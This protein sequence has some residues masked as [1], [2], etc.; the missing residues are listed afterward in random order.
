M[1]CLP[2]VAVICP[3]PQPPEVGW[4]ELQQLDELA[5]DGV[6][7]ERWS[8]EQMA[9]SRTMATTTFWEIPSN[10]SRDFSGTF[11]GHL[12]KGSPPG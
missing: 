10:A 9:A 12:P 7:P 6:E 11:F 1:F 4:A 8:G 2:L 5:A 3:L